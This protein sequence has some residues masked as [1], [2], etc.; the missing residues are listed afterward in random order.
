MDKVLVAMMGFAFVGAVTPG[1]VNLL[2]I[3]TA[4]QR[5]KRSALNHVVAASFA[6]ALVVVTSGMFMT[7]VGGWLPMFERGMQVA[8]SVFLSY[9]AYKIYTAPIGEDVDVNTQATSGWITGALTQIL[10]PKAWLVAMSG[11]SVYVIG[12]VQ[13]EQ[14]LW[15]FTLVSLFACLL[16]VGLWAMLGS[17]FSTLLSKPHCMRWFNRVMAAI[18]FMSMSM[19]WL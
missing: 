18:L 16:G 14:L 13:A 4:V 9:L 8:G 6:Y 2:A 7:R 11:I 10:N 17:V 3:S 5:G 15:V 12:Q 19:I 1:P